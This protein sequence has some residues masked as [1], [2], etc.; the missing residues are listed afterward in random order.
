MARLAPALTVALGLA[1]L[2]LCSPPPCVL[3]QLPS[4]AQWGT[5]GTA[6]I[7]GVFESSNRVFRLEWRGVE[8]TMTGRTRGWIS[9]GLNSDGMMRNSDK[10]VG[11][12]DDSSGLVVAVDTFCTGH[13]I[14]RPDSEF[15]GVDNLENVSGSQNSTHTV[16]TFRRPLDTGDKY[17]KRIVDGDTYVL[18]AFWRRD[19]TS[20]T[21][22]D[23]HGG[24]YGL[25]Y[26]SLVVNLLSP[27]PGVIVVPPSQGLGF[28]KNAAQAVAL[29]VAVCLVL[30]AAAR[31]A[32]ASLGGYDVPQGR[33]KDELVMVGST[34][35][36]LR[37]ADARAAAAGVELAANDA[38]TADLI[39][40]EDASEGLGSEATSASSAKR[41]AWPTPVHRPSLAQ[42]IQ[43]VLLYRI[44]SDV[45]VWAALVAALFVAA[46][47]AWGL[48]WATQLSNEDGPTAL[49]RVTGHLTSVAMLVTVVPATRNS[50]LA[51]LLGESFE[52]TL[53]FHRWI[54]WWTLGMLAVHTALFFIA[55][56]SGVVWDGSHVIAEQVFALCGLVCCAVIVLGSLPVV[57]RGAYTTFYVMHF[58]FVPFFLL[59]ALH[60]EN[61]IPFAVAAAVIWGVDRAGRLLWGTMPHRR[62]VR[63]RWWR[64]RLAPRGEAGQYVFVNFPQLSLVEWH[65]FTLASG[66]REDILE[67]DIKAL[68]HH[69][70]RMAERLPAFASSGTLW[71]RADGPY[72]HMTLDPADYHVAVLVAGGIGVTP[73][74][75]IVRSVYGIARLADGTVMGGVQRGRPGALKALRLHWSVT[76]VGH[77]TLFS[78]V[79][80]AAALS[81]SNDPTVPA[82][83][84]RL[85]VTKGPAEV[86]NVTASPGRMDV[87][88]VLDAVA[89]DYPG[90]RVAVVACGPAA[91]TRAAW[92]AVARH[93]RRGETMDVHCETFTF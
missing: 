51:L 44:R 73:M 42:R 56:G 77:Y 70:R 3:E 65:P 43:G 59:A 92:D 47:L 67:V 69:T 14:P 26:G 55:R 9:F 52:R 4:G 41:P 71:V 79:F 89:A 90:Q 36:E 30:A 61:F 18:W 32:S 76:G 45:P 84:V 80:E 5:N 37:A 8:F 24:S 40:Q 88:R 16:I 91:M 78:D 35:V 81:R 12:V 66:P 72:G 15:G 82:F 20:I 7:H 46:N 50:L 25:D 85:H 31:L 17:D 49:A 21:F 83:D 48:Y 23:V 33:S 27:P 64:T 2:S 60:N 1:A 57:R 10:Y 6:N 75:A 86:P 34:A 29:T 63:L 87:A 22:Y 13:D 28:L 58:L 19:G 68:G 38:S 54:G 62:I 93:K 11:W 39:D 74:V 53:M